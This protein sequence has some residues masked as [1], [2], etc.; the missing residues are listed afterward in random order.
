MMSGNGNN[1]NWGSAIRS[2]QRKQNIKLQNNHSDNIYAF[3]TKNTHKYRRESLSQYLVFVW[4][5]FTAF[6]TFV[7]LVSGY[8]VF[9]L[10]RAQLEMFAIE[11][12]QPL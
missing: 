8:P 12:L 11:P 6:V 10:L 5:Y 3:L 1:L 7:S 9:Y 4:L 2:V